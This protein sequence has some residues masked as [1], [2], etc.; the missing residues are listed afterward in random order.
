MQQSGSG[1]VGPKSS[2]IQNFRVAYATPD[3]RPKSSGSGWVGP[4]IMEYCIVVDILS[5]NRLV[6]VENES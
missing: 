2:D 3:S 5:S 1:R 4:K 6:D